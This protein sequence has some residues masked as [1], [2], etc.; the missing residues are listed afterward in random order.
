MQFIKGPKDFWAGILFIALGIF[1]IVVGS[2]YTLGT[3]ARMG[4]G[5]FPRILGIL[6]IGL[7]ALIAFNG[8]RVPGESIPPFKWRPTLVVLG[9]VVIYGIIIQNLGV[10]I[11]TVFLIVAS[12][13]ASHEFRW[14]EALI[15][16]VLLSAL[17]VLVFIKGLGL[18][19]PIWPTFLAH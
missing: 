11:S 14:K 5:Y 4:P 19:L 15:A 16:G 8:L 9:S 10:A 1:A 17:A 12:S 7:G 18:Q 6:L 2:N 3:A 13:A